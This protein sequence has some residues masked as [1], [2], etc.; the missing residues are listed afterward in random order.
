MS[1]SITLEPLTELNFDA[2]VALRVADDQ[3]RYVASNVLSIAQSK[4]WDYLFPVVIASDKAP[5]GFA[6]WGRD[7]GTTRVYL[8]RLMI[9][10][11]H[12]RRGHGK[13]ATRLLV[14]HVF[15]ETHCADLY[16]SIVPGNIAAEGLYRSLGFL[17]TGE[18][19]GDG[20][21]L[22]AISKSQAF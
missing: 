8:V 17:P 20:E 15:A 7:P 12:Q 21:V 4:V 18:T 3:T 9:D 5:I 22:Y 2:V 19:D 16:L 11:D 1:V 14:S 10:R 13:V 6:L